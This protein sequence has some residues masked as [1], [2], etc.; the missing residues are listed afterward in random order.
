MP[1]DLDYEKTLSEIEESSKLNGYILLNL[2]VILKKCSLEQLAVGLYLYRFSNV[3]QNIPIKNEEKKNELKGFPQWD[4]FNLDTVLTPFLIEKYNDRFKKGFIEL[5]SR[6][7]IFA[8]EE[9]VI[10]NYENV[11]EYMEEIV[12]N[13]RV[14]K[15][16]QYISKVI[17]YYPIESLNEII[18][19]IVGEIS[20]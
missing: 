17:E 15:K 18:S 19:K 11:S 13:I 7:L 2:I 14:H 1:R 16:C 12:E 3:L 5:L 10:L 8:K 6:N 20:D 4:Y 9:K